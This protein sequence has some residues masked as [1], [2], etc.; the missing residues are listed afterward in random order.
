[1]WFVNKILKWT[2][3]FVDR[4]AGIQFNILTI[5]DH[6]WGEDKMGVRPGVEKTDG[7]TVGGK[8]REGDRGIWRER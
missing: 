4:G 5:L 1:M 7:E 6:C 3:L 2:T 8:E